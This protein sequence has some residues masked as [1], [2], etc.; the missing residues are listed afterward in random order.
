MEARRHIFR[1]A[2]DCATEP[3]SPAEG[4][5]AMLVDQCGSAPGED[6]PPLRNFDSECNCPLAPE[7]VEWPRARRNMRR[8][9]RLLLQLERPIIGTRQ[10]ATVVQQGRRTAMQHAEALEALGLVEIRPGTKGL[11]EDAEASVYRVLRPPWAPRCVSAH[12]EKAAVSS[13][14]SSEETLFLNS[15]DIGTQGVGELAPPESAAAFVDEDDRFRPGRS[16]GYGELGLSIVRLCARKGWPQFSGREMARWLADGTAHTSVNRVLA[17]MRA[18][19]HAE[20]IA[21]NTWRLTIKPRISTAK[22]D[23]VM[24]TVHRLPCNE[25]RRLLLRRLSGY[26]HN[27]NEISME[28]SRK[29]AQES[30]AHRELTKDRYAQEKDAERAVEQGALLAN[31]GYLPSADGPITNHQAMSPGNSARP[32]RSP[33]AARLTP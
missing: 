32:R 30:R 22:Y 3:D 24:E 1:S 21:N 33:V 29:Y 5:I 19:G 13:C 20:R 8:T 11:E 15:L 31:E 28:R 7:Q 23:L 27:N 17:K 18:N 10:L 14:K 9:Y 6:R 2:V 26:I 4:L 12:T 16:G 25:E